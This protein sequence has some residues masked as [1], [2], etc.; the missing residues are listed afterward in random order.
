M[1]K[2]SFSFGEIFSRTLQ[3]CR[4]LSIINELVGRVCSKTFCKFSPSLS[5][6]VCQLKSAALSSAHYQINWSVCDLLSVCNTQRLVSL[7]IKVCGVVSNEH[8]LLKKKKLKHFSGDQVVSFE[9][10]E[11]MNIMKRSVYLTFPLTSFLLFTLKLNL[12]HF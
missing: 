8:R 5:L 6:G 12:S 7:W 9:D 10:K 1:E 2:G 11:P 3:L 4:F